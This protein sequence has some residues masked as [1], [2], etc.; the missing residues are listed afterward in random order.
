MCGEIDAAHCSQRAS[1]ASPNVPLNPRN[2]SDRELFALGTSLA[3]LRDGRARRGGGAES[4]RA[5]CVGVSSGRRSLQEGAEEGGL[6]RPRAVSQSAAEASPQP[7][8]RSAHDWT[9]HGQQG[10][11]KL[12]YS[13]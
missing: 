7:D 2:L 9:R 1:D 6:L 12:P 11:F 4:R 13:S 3:H 10:T 8:A 5:V